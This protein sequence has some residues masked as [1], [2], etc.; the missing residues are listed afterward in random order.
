MFPQFLCEPNVN[1]AL[2]EGSDSAE[3]LAIKFESGHMALTKTGLNCKRRVA[4]LRWT[5]GLCVR[6]RRSGTMA[7]AHSFATIDRFIAFRRRVWAGHL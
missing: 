1:I 3:L 5:I 2:R 4:V 7:R 6:D